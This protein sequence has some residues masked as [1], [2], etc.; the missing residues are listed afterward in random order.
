M[1]AP[2]ELHELVARANDLAAA[3]D[4]LA[5]ELSQADPKGRA[6]FRLPNAAGLIRQAALELT[7]SATEL[8]R[9]TP[10]PV[11]FCRMGWGVCPEH[12]STLI[13]MGTM[14]RCA[15]FGCGR[16]WEYQREVVPCAE[17][18][19]H[20]VVDADGGQTPVCVGHAAYARDSV[21]PACA[22][23]SRTLR[24]WHGSSPWRASSTAR[25]RAAKPLELDESS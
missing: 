6:G 4:T 9:A 8:T 23:Q 7:D 24:P 11:T 1:S 2:A 14:T 18:A 12:G 22:H 3:V 16:V 19:T 15:V 25:R 10:R 13:A 20:R 21:M 17:L 5:G